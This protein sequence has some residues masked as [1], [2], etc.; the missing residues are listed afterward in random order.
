MIKTLVFLWIYDLP[1]E[2]YWLDY[3][4]EQFVWPTWRKLLAGLLPVPGA[5]GLDFFK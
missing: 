1:G 4:Q 2:N 5:V 3:Y